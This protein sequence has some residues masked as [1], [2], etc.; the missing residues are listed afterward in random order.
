MKR[1]TIFVL[2][3][4]CAIPAFTFAQVQD[5]ITPPNANLGEIVIS[6]QYSP[7]SINKAVNNVTVLNRQRLENL[8]AVTLAD[9]LNQVM[10]ISILPNAGTGR[11]TVKMFGLDAQY[12]TILVD[13]VPMIS[14]EGFGNNTDLTQINLDDIEQV[15]IVEGAMGVDY[16]ANAVTGIINIITK[17][18][19]IHDWNVNFF[20][21]EETVGDEY[22]LKNKGKHI[23]GLTI[24]HN[25][26]DNLY[27]SVSYTHNDFKGWFNDRKGFTYYGD[28]DKRGHE[29][30]PKNQNNVK[31]LLNYH[32]KSYRVFYKFEY[33]D[34]RMKDYSKTFEVNEDPVFETID[35]IA[36]DRITNTKRWSNILN[37]S[38]KF[39]DLFRFDL[40]FTYQ[41]QE[42]EM[43]FYRYR[44]K[45]D[46]KFDKNSYKSESREVF[47]SRGTFS[48]FIKWE[49]A[50]FQVGY[51]VANSKGYSLMSESLGESPQSKSLGSYD[52]YAS[53]E[54]DVMPNFMI[55]PGYRLMTSNTFDSQ[56]AMS[57]MLKYVLPNDY[58]IRATVGTSPRLPNYEELYTYFVDVNHDLQGNPNLNPEKGKTFFLNIKKAAELSEDIEFSSSLTG[59][60]LNVQDKIDVIQIIDPSGLK[61]KYHNVNRYRNIGVT[62]LNQL[63]WKTL[64]VGLGFTY[65]GAAQQIYG[66]P[67]DTDK[68]LYTPEVTANV[69]YKLPSTG[70]M[71]SLYY[72]F[73]GEEYR[74]KMESDLFGEYYM[75]GKQESYSWM[76]FSVRQPFFK[77]MLFA[78]VGVRN[79]FDV[80]DLTST[81]SS[82]TAH[83][84]SSP[85]QPLGYGRSF[86]VKLQYKL[87]F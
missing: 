55:R 82:G 39:Q 48:D 65:S 32:H 29:W 43:D 79:I 60:F 73:N 46:E 83:S 86:F 77:N 33:F 25:I 18:N 28:E 12:F 6:G 42:R 38:G 61:Y 19:N 23:Q 56:H 45:Y 68:F 87:G 53:S 27:A 31:A 84:S 44:I 59:R 5:T 2:S 67:S 49:R 11:S 62:F 1:N 3:A 7:Q 16:G 75:K 14:D 58:E 74:Y 36:K 15:E 54:I 71:F 76:D 9:A 4:F 66:A 51:E 13:N 40:S 17:K 24:G 21:Q 10:N 37:T 72:K 35:P 69:S 22:N 64:D 78:T 41:K 30:L 26:N 8:G 50:R 85:S 81:T 70:T 52:F 34:E 20:T 57:L 63:R 80:K 47:F